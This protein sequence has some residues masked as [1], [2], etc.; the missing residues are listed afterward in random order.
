LVLPPEFE[1]KAQQ[2]LA[3]H[4]STKV[5]NVNP[6]QKSLELIVEPRLAESAVRYLPT[7][8]TAHDGLAHTFL[9]GQGAL[10]V[11]TREEMAQVGGENAAHVGA[12]PFHVR[13]ERSAGSSLDPRSPSAGTGIGRFERH[14][15]AVGVE[16]LLFELT[17]KTGASRSDLAVIGRHDIRDGLLTFDQLKTGMLAE[18]LSM[19]ATTRPQLPPRCGNLGRTGRPRAR[20]IA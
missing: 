9:I 19:D 15:P 11:E 8:P 13:K 17:L 5:L 12:G 14:C 18:V 2:A 4:I 1:T 3:E 10:H 20:S 6:Y 16:R 7:N